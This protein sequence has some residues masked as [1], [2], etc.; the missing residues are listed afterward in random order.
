M[1]IMV[2]PR[3]GNSFSRQSQMYHRS[4]F[5]P[6][7]CYLLP[8]FSSLLRLVQSPGQTAAGGFSTRGRTAHAPVAVEPIH[9]QGSWDC[10]SQCSAMPG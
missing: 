5:S 6:L 10:W 7:P 2:D 4:G 3:V 9:S 8:S 1:D